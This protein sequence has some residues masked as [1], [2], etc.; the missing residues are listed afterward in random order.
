MK[1]VRKEGRKDMKDMK[2]GRKKGR[3]DGR[4]GKEGQQCTSA[5]RVTD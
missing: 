1:E 4:K 3:K 2:E 5:L